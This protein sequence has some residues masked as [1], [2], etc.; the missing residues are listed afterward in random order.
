[1]DNEDQIKRDVRLA[2][3]RARERRKLS[4][5]ELARGL[6]DVL[7][8][9]V[10]Q[11]QV[12]DW[13]RGRY[14]PGASVLVAV[15]EATRIPLPELLGP[16]TASGPAPTRAARGAA[17]RRWREQAREWLGMDAEAFVRTLKER[18]P[19]PLPSEIADSS[20]EEGAPAGT[21][22]LVRQP[23]MGGDQ[24][25]SVLERLLEKPLADRF[26]DLVRVFGSRTDLVS[27]LPTREL[28]RGARR[29][30][31]A[32]LSLNILCQEYADVELGALLRRGC[33]MSCLFLAPD[34]RA[35]AD[36]EREEGFPPGKLASL[37]QLNIETMLMIRRR[38]PEDVRG[39]LHLATYD[40]AA[41][42]NV[43][44]VDDAR[45]IVQPYLPELRG[46]GSPS[47]LLQRK[48]GEEGLYPLFHELFELLWEE[49]SDIC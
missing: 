29:V 37:T 44:L 6:G 28:L 35:M 5:G 31:A 39:R 4:Q 45:A 27:Q 17:A 25:G 40:E 20:S 26:T 48:G 49:R 21:A 2:I 30:R 9:Q 8:K 22:L 1:M 19:W 7:G 43:V 32:G 13:E 12:S 33:E 3:R 38:L 36:R 47:F 18:F 23:A 24:E 11:S 42:F 15:A 41:R 46:L 34:G 10:S 14:E 16:A